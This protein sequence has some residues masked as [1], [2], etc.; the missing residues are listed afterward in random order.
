MDFHD[1]V[2]F[3]HSHVTMVCSS[4]ISWEFHLVVKIFSEQ[5]IFKILMDF[6]KNNRI[7]AKGLR[8]SLGISEMPL[9]QLL[10]R[11]KLS[12]FPSL[13]FSVGPISS[14]KTWTL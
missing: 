10:L 7:F 5:R 8:I 4:G 1:N 9:C 12:S 11:R 2:M 13:P 3:V 6:L 14:S